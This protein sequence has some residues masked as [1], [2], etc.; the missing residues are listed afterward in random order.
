MNF[1]NN[2]LS[3]SKPK[4]KSTLSSKKQTRNYENDAANYENALRLQKG[5]DSSECITKVPNDSLYKDICRDERITN[6]FSNSSV[7]ARILKNIALYT[8][9]SAN[10]YGFLY[11]MSD[12]RSDKFSILQDRWITIAEWCW[13]H[14]QTDVGN[15]V[16]NEITYI[17]DQPKFEDM[18]QLLSLPTFVTTEFCLCT[19]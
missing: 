6:C 10:V 3:K 18:P 12:T 11:M 2:L 14:W 4:D 7:K 1:I 15:T 9:G 17:Y 13:A 5:Y 19:N 8:Q 16:K